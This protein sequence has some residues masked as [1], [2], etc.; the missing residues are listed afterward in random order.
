MLIGSR[1][2]IPFDPAEW[3]ARA[4]TGRPAYLGRGAREGQVG[5]KRV[6]KLRPAGRASPPV[7]TLNRDL[8]PR[9]EYAVK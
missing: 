9:D 3:A 7:A 2:P 8:W 5:R 4:A 6:A 1:E